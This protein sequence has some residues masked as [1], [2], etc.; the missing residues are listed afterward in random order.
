MDLIIEIFFRGLIVDLPGGISRYLFFKIIG[1]SK[2]M[3]HFTTGR[4]IKDNKAISQHF[5]NVIV[6]LVMLCLISIL[7]AYLFFG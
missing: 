5:P 1:K 7:G 3:K 6:G 2:S 4:K